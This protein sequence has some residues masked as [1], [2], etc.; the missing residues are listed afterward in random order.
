MK[1]LLNGTG[2]ADGIPAL[3]TPSRVGDYAREHKGKDIRTRTGALIDGHLKIDFGPETNFQCARDGVDARDWSAIFFTHS[4][5]DHLSVAEIQYML[6]PFNLNTFAP[7]TIFA[8]A[9]VSELL[10]Q[11][12]PDWPLEIVETQSFSAFDYMGYEVIPISAYHKLDEDSQNIIFKRDGVTFLYATDTGIWREPTWEFLKD[13][14]IDGMVIECTDGKN[15][16]GYHGHLN[17]EDCLAV[18]GRMQSQGSLK[19]SAKIVTTHHSH[20]G[21]ATHAE[22]EALLN[23]HGIDVGYDGMEF[24]IL[25]S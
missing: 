16:S 9:R 21:D 17:I 3:F 5:E 10:N 19:P 2:G 23:P 15:F 18:V 14:Q 4:H 12:F 20:Y 1:I 6:Y 8:N 24:E 7:I 22:L 11:R 25:P 13:L